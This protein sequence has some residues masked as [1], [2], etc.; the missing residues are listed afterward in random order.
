M[1]FLK[2][3]AI[4]CIVSISNERERLIILKNK[5]FLP[6]LVCCIA[7]ALCMAGCAPAV[8]VRWNMHATLVTADGTVEDSFSLPVAGVISEIEER[9]Y[10]NLEVE[11]PKSIPYTM[12][13][14]ESNGDPVDSYIFDR[15]GDMATQGFCYDI[16]NDSLAWET[17][18]INIEKQYFIAYWGK[19]YGKFLVASVDPNVKPAEIMEHFDYLAE[20]MIEPVEGK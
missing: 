6:F 13:F 7:V 5:V 4:W 17:W 19:E 18:A 12:S 20:Y 3:T 9:H 8:S 15:E 14:C 2:K 11:L 16:K 1:I 10:L